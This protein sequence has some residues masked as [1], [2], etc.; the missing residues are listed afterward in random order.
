MK[1]FLFFLLMTAGPLRTL[2]QTAT[3]DE[4][5][6]QAVIE[7]ETQAYLDRNACQQADCW[8]SQTELSQRVSLE[9][10]RVVV[11]NGNQASLRRGL[12]S[13]FTELTEPD[14]ACFANASYHIRIKGDGAFVTFSQTVHATGN[15]PGQQSQQTRYLEREAGQWKIV[16]SSVMYH[17]S[18]QTPQP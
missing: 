13:C 14:T 10:G 11:A 2:A 5:A 16:H 18:S 9:S 15:R 1:S 8:A 4:R 12:T 6:V 17:E 7:Q 3:T